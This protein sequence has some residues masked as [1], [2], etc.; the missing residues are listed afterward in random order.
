MKD[1]FQKK[2]ACSWVAVFFNPAYQNLAFI[3]YF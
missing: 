3:Y 2:H 1:N